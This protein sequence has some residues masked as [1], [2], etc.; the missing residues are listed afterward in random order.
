MLVLLCLTV[1]GAW[2][3]AQWTGGTYTATAT[4]NLGAITVNADATLTINEG[5]TVTVTG[6]INVASG[7]LTVAG[8]GTLVVTGAKGNDG[9]NYVIMNNGGDGGNGGNAFAGTL[10]YKSGTVTA[11]GGSG[12]RKWEN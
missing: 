11:N 7:T 4:E 9:G 10:T 3:G 5:V 12:G 2:A 6:G 1:S 8:P